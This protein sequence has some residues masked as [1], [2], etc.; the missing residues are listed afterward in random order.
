VE[1]AHHRHHQSR[2]DEHG[3]SQTEEM[4]GHGRHTNGKVRKNFSF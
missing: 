2:G 3:C 1:P 4:D